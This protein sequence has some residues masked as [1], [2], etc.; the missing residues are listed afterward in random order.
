MFDELQKKKKKVRV[1]TAA[2]ECCAS[3]R[4]VRPSKH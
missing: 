3:T 2:A 4:H 1:D